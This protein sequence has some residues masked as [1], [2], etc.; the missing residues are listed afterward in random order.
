[1]ARVLFANSM[2]TPILHLFAPLQTSVFTTIVYTGDLVVYM[3]LM[4]MC[5]FLH[6]ILQQCSHA[7]VVYVY[8][9]KCRARV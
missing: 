6:Q 9:P 7:P 8:E 1:M 2:C 3:Q 4:N 5:T